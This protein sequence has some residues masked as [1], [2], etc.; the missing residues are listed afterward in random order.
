MRITHM[1][2]LE[3][4]VFFRLLLPEYWLGHIVHTTFHAGWSSLPG[5]CCSSVECSSAVISFCAITAAV[6]PRPEDVT[7]PVIVLFTMVSTCVTDCNFN[8]ARCP[9]N[10]L[11]WSVALNFTLTLNYFS[12]SNSYS[13]VTCSY[14]VMSMFRLLPFSFHCSVFIL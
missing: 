7:V 8:T 6:P 2:H 11:S 9:C 1:W 10:G 12:P 5:G 13:T 14:K 4:P 3:F